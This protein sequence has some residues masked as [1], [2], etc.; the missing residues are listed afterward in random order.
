MLIYLA[1][2]ALVVFAALVGLAQFNL[3]GR[4]PVVYDKLSL[5]DVAP[6]IRSW[7]PWLAE[8]G[9]IVARH[10][11][12]DAEVEFRKRR[13]SSQPDV[14]MFRVRN[15]DASKHHFPAIRRAFDA[16]ATQYELELTAKR[17]GPRAIAVALVAED[18]H[19]PAA[20]CNLLALT[21]S[22]V[23]AVG[24]G[25]RIHSEGQMRQAPDAPSVPLAPWRRDYAAGFRFGAL[26][27]RARSRILKLF[28]LAA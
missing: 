8:R 23:G 13:Y 26:L 6:L 15:A 27:G 25:F 17:R 18:V 5:A 19:T 10:A 9:R 7:G 14:L 12:S 3:W 2:G 11:D 4:R 21:F 22:A 20:A 24:N 16:S 1:I 28:G